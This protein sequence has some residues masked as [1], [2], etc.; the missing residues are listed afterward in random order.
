MKLVKK[1]SRLLVRKVLKAPLE[2]STTI[3]VG[4]ELIDAPA[5]RAYKT[6]ALRHDVFDDL[7]DNLFVMGEHSIPS[8]ERN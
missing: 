2:D 7:L 8:A 5:E 6:K 4:R 1:R 3:W